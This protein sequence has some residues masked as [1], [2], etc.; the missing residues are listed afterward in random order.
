MIF[1]ST[2]GLKEIIFS[3]KLALEKKQVESYLSYQ[4]LCSQKRFFQTT[5]LDQMH[6]SLNRAGIILD[7]YLLSF[8]CPSLQFAQKDKNQAGGEGERIHCF[9]R[10]SKFSRSRNSLKVITGKT[11]FG[12]KRYVLSLQTKGV[13]FLTN[14]SSS[15]TWKPWRWMR[16][17]F[18]L[19]MGYINISFTFNSFTKNNCNSRSTQI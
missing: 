7:L 15:N 8:N 12:K 14:G 10:I 18:S 5:L 4:D 11:G 16:F 9:I 17:D 3:F 6:W 2:T 1:L 13:T 19:S